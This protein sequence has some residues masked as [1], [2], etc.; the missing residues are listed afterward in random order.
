MATVVPAAWVGAEA[1]LALAR[2]HVRLASE[3]GRTRAGQAR[4][5]LPPKEQPRNVRR[6]AYRL[7]WL[8]AEEE[9]KLGL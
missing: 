6:D 4:A 7:A 5:D 2:A 9:A 3:V 1:A 8:R